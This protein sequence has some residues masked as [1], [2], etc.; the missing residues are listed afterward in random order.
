[1]L[2]LTSTRLIANEQAY[3]LYCN[4]HTIVV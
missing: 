2:S 3:V 4:Q 1:V